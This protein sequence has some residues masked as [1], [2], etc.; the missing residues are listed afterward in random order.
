MIGRDRKDTWEMPTPPSTQGDH[1]DN[2]IKRLRPN[3]KSLL[4]STIQW[5][6]FSKSYDEIEVFLNLMSAGHRDYPKPSRVF[7]ST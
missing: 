7:T 5:K 6:I 4:D 1:W 3:S 2:F